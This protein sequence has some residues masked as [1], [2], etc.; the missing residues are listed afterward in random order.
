MTHDTW[1]MAQKNSFEKIMWKQ[2]KPEAPAMA[3]A[4]MMLDP[5]AVATRLTSSGTGDGGPGPAGPGAPGALWQLWLL[6][7]WQL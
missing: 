7:V 3:V 6:A 1:H 4:R 5:L 2:D